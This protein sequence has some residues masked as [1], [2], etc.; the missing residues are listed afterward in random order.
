MF[1]VVF[2]SHHI[3]CGIDCKNKSIS[4]FIISKSITISEC[5]ETSLLCSLSISVGWYVCEC[6]PIQGDLCIVGILHSPGALHF[7]QSPTLGLHE[8][9]WTSAKLL[10]E[11]SN[12]EQEVQLKCKRQEQAQVK[13]K[14]EPK[15][16]LIGWRS[17]GMGEELS[18]KYSNHISP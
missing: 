7:A 17:V 2:D 11:E 14:T 1:Y 16:M 6:T 5:Q 4:K 10:I 8:N 12:E 9:Q 13:E 15:R 3:D 18:V